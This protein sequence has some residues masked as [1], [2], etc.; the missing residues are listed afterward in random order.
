MF[1]LYSNAQVTPAYIHMGR[2]CP[3]SRNNHLLWLCSYSSMNAMCITIFCTHWPIWI[4][5][6]THTSLTINLITLSLTCASCHFMNNQKTHYVILLLSPFCI[7]YSLS[8]CVCIYDLLLPQDMPS[9]T[10]I[11]QQEEWGGS[12]WAACGFS[13]EQTC[14]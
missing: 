11:W 1:W 13:N 5:I 7:S 10:F 3:C 4:S 12:E 2:R 6:F 9:L 14:D 8:H